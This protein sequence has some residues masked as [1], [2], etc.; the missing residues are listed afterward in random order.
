M[1]KKKNIKWRC[2]PKVDNEGGPQGSD[3]GPGPGVSGTSSRTGK[4]RWGEEAARPRPMTRVGPVRVPLRQGRSQ[5][6]WVRHVDHLV[7]GWRWCTCSL[8]NMNPGGPS[9]QGTVFPAT[10]QGV[11]DWE[12]LPG[13]WFL[14]CFVG[15]RIPS[16]AWC[17]PWKFQVS[18][19][20]INADF[21]R[22]LTCEE[23]ELEEDMATH[24][25][26]LAWRIPMDR[27]A[28]RAEEPGSISPVHSVTKSQTW[29]SNSAQA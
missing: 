11:L 3:S 25:S 18:V 21:I 12:A 27:G 6:S 29:L 16:I 14:P 5:P 22:L 8:W 20:F 28:W 9:R 24:S 26:I 19:T 1:K 23:P 2:F 13:A 15:S 10:L 17:F 4:N 7:G